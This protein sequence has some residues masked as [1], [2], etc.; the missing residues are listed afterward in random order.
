M[1]Y[2]IIIIK[3]VDYLQNL[4]KELAYASRKQN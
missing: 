3:C 1:D 4:L 2:I